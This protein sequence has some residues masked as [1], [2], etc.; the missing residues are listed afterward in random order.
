MNC[1]CELPE[2]PAI[3]GV[4]KRIN[5]E[6]VFEKAIKDPYCNEKQNSLLVLVANKL[7]KPETSTA[8]IIHTGFIT[9][10]VKRSYL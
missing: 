6:V 7:K 9:L 10:M 3:K 5:P 1:S 2:Y 4:S 8:K